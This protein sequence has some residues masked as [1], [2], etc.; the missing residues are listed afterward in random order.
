[1]ALVLLNPNARGGRTAGLA[2]PLAGWLRTHAPD[3]V[4]QAPPGIAAARQAIADT[5][6]PRVVV[7]GGDGT[8]HQVLPALH[9]RGCEVG[10]VPAGSGDDTARAWGLRGLPWAQ[11]LQHAL[12]APATPVDLGEAVT[13]HE[14]RLFVSSLAAGFDAAVATRALAGPPRL[15]GLLRYLWATLQELGALRLHELQVT[16][17]GR[18][19]HAGPALF[20]STLLT[21]SYGGGM[22]AAPAARIDDG[23]LDLL[24]AG[25]FGRAAA[26]AMLPRLLTGTHRS[27]ARVHLHPFTQADLDAAGPLPLAA[28]GEPMVA[29]AQLRLRVHPAAL[30]A[31][32]RTT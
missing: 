14:S 13:A 12:Q 17:D 2:A 18:A 7:V 31:V 3:S 21:P 20:A 29:A 16:V 9:A 6:A 11:A 19:V 27:H 30:R 22:P 28:D 10:L 4:L 8:L 1:M 24:L 5:A 32:R 15:A 26:L 25:R 23:R